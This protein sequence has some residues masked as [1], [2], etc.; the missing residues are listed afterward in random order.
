MPTPHIEVD[1]SNSGPESPIHCA[2]SEEKTVAGLTALDRK[3]GK[4]IDFNLMHNAKH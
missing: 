4:S 2:T 1:E 3:S